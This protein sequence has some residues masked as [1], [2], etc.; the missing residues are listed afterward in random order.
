[1]SKELRVV[2]DFCRRKYDET[3]QLCVL[4]DGE[5]LSKGSRVCVRCLPDLG[6]TGCT[7][8]SGS[9]YEYDRLGTDDPPKSWEY[10]R[11]SWREQLA[12]LAGEWPRDPHKH[13]SDLAWHDESAAA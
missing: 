13:R 7:F 12:A 10:D 9:G 2:C 8:V 3:E 11:P 1:M 6:I 4:I 5:H